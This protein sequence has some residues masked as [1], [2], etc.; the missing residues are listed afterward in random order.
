MRGVEDYLEEIKRLEEEGD[1]ITA[2]VVAR[3]LDVSL[4]SASEMLKR[5]A[6]EGYL[7]RE[8]NGTIL[9]TPEG[10]RLAHTILR[11]HRLIECLLVQKL[12]MAWH[13]VHA[14]AHR[15]EHAIS[16]RVE[17]AMAQAL[18]YPD[19]CPHGHPI[20]PVDLRQLKRLS[21]LDAG[22]SGTIAQISE[23]DEVL[24]YLDQIGVRPG[25]EVHVKDVAPLEGPLTIETEDGITPLGRELASLVRIA[26]DR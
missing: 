5:L 19:L 23:N 18:D 4:P 21:L 2:T 6:A 12:G 20:C 9:L 11:R 13:E 7:L 15:I 8:R 1:R 26:T 17:E 3:I 16:A 25:A 14:E 22:E 10:R 24:A